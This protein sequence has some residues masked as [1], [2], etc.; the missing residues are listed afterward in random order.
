MPCG[1]KSGNPC[2]KGTGLPVLFSEQLPLEFHHPM[3]L[4]NL[5]W[6]DHSRTQISIQSFHSKV[7]QRAFSHQDGW[8]NQRKR[9]V[10]S[11]GRLLGQHEPEARCPAHL[12]AGLHLSHTRS[13]TEPAFL[14]YQAP[15]CNVRPTYYRQEENSFSWPQLKRL[16]R[17]KMTLENSPKM[18]ESSQH[19]AG[20]REQ[21][22]LTMLPS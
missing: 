10:L 16:A 13:V 7:E 9:G 3:D 5:G 8:R 1:L 6:G 2:F 15:M 14:L 11:P 19:W 12:L 21:L 22:T 4:D 20:T 18:S 17:A